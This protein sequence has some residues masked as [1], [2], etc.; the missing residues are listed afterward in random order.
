ML[1]SVRPMKAG[2]EVTFDY[3]V[4]VKDN[5]SVGAGQHRHDMFVMAM[6]GRLRGQVGRGDQYTRLVIDLSR[7]TYSDKGTP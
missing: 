3:F 7:V 2:E 4:G 6:E 1:V 5:D